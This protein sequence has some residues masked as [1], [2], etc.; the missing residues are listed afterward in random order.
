MTP[1]LTRTIALDTIGCAPRTLRIDADDAERQALA[2]RFDLI[3]LDRLSADL[4]FAVEATNVRVHGKLEAALTQKCAATGRPVDAKIKEPID[5]RFIPPVDLTPGQDEI[6]IEA[7]ACDEIEHDGRVVDL[8]EA[9]AQ[10]LGLALD[11][12]PRSSDADAV[13]KEAG[14]LGE[15]ETG[16]FAALKG[17]F[18]K[19]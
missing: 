9:V 3:A 17:L 2:R 12:Y 7:D 15:H 10:T 4:T 11:P 1:E 5:L 18:N 6:E 14:V 8:G 16:P 13:L 19:E